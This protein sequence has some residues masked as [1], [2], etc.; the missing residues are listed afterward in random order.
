V[1]SLT[2]GAAGLSQR[3]ATNHKTMFLIGGR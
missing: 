3:I 1:W 2:V